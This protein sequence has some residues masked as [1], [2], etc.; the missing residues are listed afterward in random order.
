M[1]GGSINI[2]YILRS[3]SRGAQCARY[4]VA[5]INVGPP[6]TCVHLTYVE[7]LQPTYTHIYARPVTRTP[8]TERKPHT[9]VAKEVDVETMQGMHVKVEKT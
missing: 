3:L 8:T 6:A 4:P 9:R 5:T 7:A 2:I 1:V